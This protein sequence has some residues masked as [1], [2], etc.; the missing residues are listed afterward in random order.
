MQR[1]QAVLATQLQR[2]CEERKEDGRAV[3][4]LIKHLRKM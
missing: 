3:A 1:S 2:A 4:S